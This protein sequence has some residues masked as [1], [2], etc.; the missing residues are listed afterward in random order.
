MHEYLR[1][2]G[3]KT[4]KCRKLGRFNPEITIQILAAAIIHPLSDTVIDIETAQVVSRTPSQDRIAIT[5]RRL[6]R[7]PNPS[8]K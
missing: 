8:L 1:P 3:D 6:L 7:K 4:N 2:S 5:I